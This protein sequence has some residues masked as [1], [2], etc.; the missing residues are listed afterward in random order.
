MSPHPLQSFVQS[1][2]M[3]HFFWG[4]GRCARVHLAKHQKTKRWPQQRGQSSFW[5]QFKVVTHAKSGAYL[6]RVRKNTLGS[7]DQSE[8]MENQHKN[9]TDKHHCADV[10]VW[11]SPFDSVKIQRRKAEIQIKVGSVITTIFNSELIDIGFTAT[12][13][14]YGSRWLQEIRFSTVLK[15]HL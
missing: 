12:F 2:C 15:F 7:S 4:G 10:Q 8:Q 9:F 13:L 11:P 14:E 1:P 3:Q 5:F 6:W